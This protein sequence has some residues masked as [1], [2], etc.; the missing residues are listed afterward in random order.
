MGDFWLYTSRLWDMLACPHPPHNGK[1]LDNN[2]LI[3]GSPLSLSR[4]CQLCQTNPHHPRCISSR[5][6]NS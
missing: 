5:D 1:E 2:D 4:G 6:R 3:E